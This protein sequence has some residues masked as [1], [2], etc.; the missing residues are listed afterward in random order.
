VIRRRPTKLQ[1]A[2]VP[3]C[4]IAYAALCHY[5][6]TVAP[7]RGLGAALALGPVCILGAVCAWRWTAPPAALA[8]IGAAGL[9]IYVA[10]PLLEKNFS[11]GYLLEECGLYGLLGLSFARSL[12]A[13]R[14]PVC[15]ALA[16]R[17]HG[18]LNPAELR[19]TRRITAAWAMFFALITATT[20]GLFL[21][22]P[23]RVWSLFSNFCVLPLVLVM[24]L[25]EYAVRCRVLPPARRAGLMATL[26]VYFAGSA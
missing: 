22:A 9:A 2:A 14:I 21:R 16:D 3:A 4:V 19:Y 10:W 25:A 18:P 8:L 7:A 24:F 20:L 5:S 17:V 15:T 6:N 11:W 23:L 1:Y 13:G 26:R 12:L